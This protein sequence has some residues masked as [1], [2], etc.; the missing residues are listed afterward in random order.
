MKIKDFMKCLAF[1]FDNNNF[2]IYD[3][4]GDIIA[5][6]SLTREIEVSV[7]EEFRNKF[8]NCDIINFIAEPHWSFDNTGIMV[9]NIKIK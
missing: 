1:P 6:Y 7:L 9:Y 3:N 5:E 4:C 8:Y 2:I